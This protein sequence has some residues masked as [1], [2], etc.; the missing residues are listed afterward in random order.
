MVDVDGIKS[1]LVPYGV[2]ERLPYTRVLQFS[3]GKVSSL[4]RPIKRFH[5]GLPAQV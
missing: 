3:T 5:V 4:L 2:Y 1:R